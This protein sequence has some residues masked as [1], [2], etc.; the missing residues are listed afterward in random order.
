MLQ[1]A[2]NRIY[3]SFDISN[4]N[5]II[6][7]SVAVGTD[8]AIGLNVDDRMNNGG[9]E[10]LELLE[11]LC[12]RVLCWVRSTERPDSAVP[13]AQTLA[14]MHKGECHVVMSLDTPPGIP[15]GIKRID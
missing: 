11:D 10:K 8:V 6:Y 2:C 12:S 9:Y 14:R 7:K 5:S 3:G 13:L 4:L 1:N 15:D